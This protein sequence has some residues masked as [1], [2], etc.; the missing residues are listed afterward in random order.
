MLSFC[1]ANI[2]NWPPSLGLGV[3]IKDM[4]LGEEIK[5]ISMKHLLIHKSFSREMPIIDLSKEFYAIN[6]FIIDISYI[7]TIIIFIFI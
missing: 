7:A 1:L 5:L 6:N 2:Q 4:Q 3:Q